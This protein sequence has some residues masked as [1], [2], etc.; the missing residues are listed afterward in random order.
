MSGALGAPPAPA[1]ERAGHSHGAGWD[2]GIRRDPTLR[3]DDAG[4]MLEGL[5]LF[6]LWEGTDHPPDAST[7]LSRAQRPTAGT[8]PPACSLHG[9]RQHAD[10]TAQQFLERPPR[11]CGQCRLGPSSAVRPP[12]A[13]PSATQP[14][15]TPGQLPS[16][17]LPSHRHLELPRNHRSS[18]G[19][20]GS[21]ALGTIRDLP[22]ASPVAHSPSCAGQG[23]RHPQKNGL[24]MGSPGPP[25]E[26]SWG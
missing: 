12:P 5:P 26:G 18:T 4:C 14:S 20:A 15:C 19:G 17:P 10:S 7:Q 2:P 23:P 9:L 1:E 22:P 25:Q 21:R 6:P 24:S 3:G 13:S 11:K 16:T 8:P